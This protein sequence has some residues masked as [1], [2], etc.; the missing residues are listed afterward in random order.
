MPGGH[1]LARLGGYGLALI[2]H[3]PFAFERVPDASNAVRVTRFTPGGP[4]QV[5]IEP[6]GN[7][8][9]GDV[10]DVADGPQTPFW[11]VETSV[12]RLRWP[13]SFTLE[14]PAETDDGTP[15]Y[16]R[17]PA[18]SMIFPQGPVE[19]DRLAD[20]QAL[21]APGQTVLQ[22]RDHEHGISV[23]ELGYRHEDRQWW[24]GHWVIPHHDDQVVVLTGQAVLESAA[25]TREAAEIMAA[26]FGR[27]H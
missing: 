11:M 27:T 18:D 20:P 3:W 23:V 15:F 7:V 24:Q 14:S 13:A 16:L 12:F 19:R 25:V 5:V 9:G 4:R 26:S 8:D 1:V 17:G 10:V 22:R 21:V 6:G 2:P